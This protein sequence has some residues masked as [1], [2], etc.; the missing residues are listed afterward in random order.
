MTQ[1]RI[2]HGGGNGKKPFR[3]PNQ[4]QM[5]SIFEPLVP[6]F[7]CQPVLTLSPVCVIK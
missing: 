2:H 4:A 1:E 7:S 6:L 5:L 3:E